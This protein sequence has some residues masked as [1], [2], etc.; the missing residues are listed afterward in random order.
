MTGKDPFKRHFRLL[1][2]QYKCSSK[3]VLFEIV[4]QSYPT[5]IFHGEPEKEQFA[6]GC[7]FYVRVSYIS[8][9]SPLS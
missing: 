7:E 9:R 5:E 8:T 6:W 3:S 4:L 2:S 1:R